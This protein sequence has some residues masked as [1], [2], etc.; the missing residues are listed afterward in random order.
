MVLAQQPQVGLMCLPVNPLGRLRERRRQK[1]QPF[2][3]TNPSTPIWTR[4]VKRLVSTVE[5]IPPILGTTLP[6]DWILAPT[7]YRE[8]GKNQ[9]PRRCLWTRRAG[10]FRFPP[11]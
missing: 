11:P 6:L 5:Q 3:K 7:I 10:K 4:R 8:L 2:L 9:A 1:R